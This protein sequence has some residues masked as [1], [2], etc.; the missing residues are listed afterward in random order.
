MLCHPD[1]EPVADNVK[2][3]FAFAF[4]KSSEDH[5]LLVEGI[6]E[7]DLRR[8]ADFLRVEHERCHCTERQKKKWTEPGVDLSRTKNRVSQQPSSARS[9]FNHRS[10]R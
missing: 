10:Q 1:V 2:L 7:L 3:F 4:R 9:R 8:L 6:G 5:P